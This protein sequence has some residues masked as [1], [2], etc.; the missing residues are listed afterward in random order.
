M[1]PSTTDADP[2][3]G[4]PLYAGMTV[5][6]AAAVVAS[7]STLAT[8]ARAAGWAGW[9]PW[10]LPGSVDVGGCV[11]GWVWLRRRAPGHD[12]L[13][14][15]GTG[16]RR[17]RRGRPRRRAGRPRA[18][19]GPARAARR[20]QRGDG[21]H[22]CPRRCRDPGRGARRRARHDAPVAEAD[23][24][25]DTRTS[26]LTA[27]RAGP[28]SVADLVK[29]TGRSR[30]TIVGHLNALSDD[31]AVVRGDDKRYRTVTGPRP[32]GAPS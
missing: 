20:S 30:T 29:V 13:P 5:A 21:P 4:W 26:V 32:V 24:P 17:H 1:T 25:V 2:S 10:L 22:A 27:L 28:A 16:P 23:D 18:P 19:R 31:G 12:R 7:A 15:P 3:T 8:L 11:G 9:T 6:G 14:A